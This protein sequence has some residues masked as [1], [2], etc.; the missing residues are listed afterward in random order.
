M[1]SVALCTYNGGKYIK[2][3]LESIVNQTMPVDE[4][5]VCDD[6]ST[7]NTIQI[8]QTIATQHQNIVFK[9]I[10]NDTNIGV[11]RN[12]EKALSF[13]N[14]DIKF[15]S[16]QDDIWEPT[17]VETVINY[18]NNNPRNDVVM[19]NA[20]LINKDDL[21]ISDKTLFD[22]IGLNKEIISICNNDILIDLFSTFNRAT[23]ATMAIKNTIPVKFDYNTPILHDYIL[24]IEALARNSMGLIEQPLIQYRIHQ[25]QECGI[26]DAI[27]HPWQNNI[28]EL[29]YEDFGNYPLPQIFLDKIKMR[30]KR[31]GWRAGLR[32]VFSIIY[33][34]RLY[35]KTYPTL[36]LS[37][38]KTDINHTIGLFKQRHKKSI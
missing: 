32:G 22:C 21:I 19:T 35:K 10:I 23:G 27:E 1:I 15:L 36:W 6:G 18:F 17:K 9:I 30:D 24:A 38:I 4:I 37:Y 16:D 29:K 5:V 2:E 31:Y 14:G 12:F 33:N 20:T 13:C 8:V 25:N 34:W 11:R 26:G 7:D 3:Q 28:Y